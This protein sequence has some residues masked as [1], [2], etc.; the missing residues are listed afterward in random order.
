M[1]LHQ[2]STPIHCRRQPLRPSD[3]WRDLYPTYEG[4]LGLIPHDFVG[5][6]HPTSSLRIALGVIES[7]IP[8]RS[9]NT[10]DELI[11]VAIGIYEGRLFFQ[12]SDQPSAGAHC[13]GSNEAVDGADLI[14]G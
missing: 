1:W 10:L 14:I 3:E 4:F 11:G 12:G 13:N 8:F 2:G 5:G 6:S 7:N 9:V